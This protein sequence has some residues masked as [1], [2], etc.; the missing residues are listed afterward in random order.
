MFNVKAGQQV[1]VN[2]RSGVVRNGDGRTW[3]QVRFDD[4]GFSQVVTNAC[5]SVQVEVV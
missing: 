2:G 1:R 3:V 5:T 4:T